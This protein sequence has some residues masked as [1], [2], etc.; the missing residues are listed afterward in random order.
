MTR[1]VS[2]RSLTAEARLR[3]QL[4]RVRFAVDKV[5]LGQIF[6]RILRLFIIK[7]I[8]PV[9]H[10]HLLLCVALIS[11]T[12]GRRLRAFQKEMLFRK[13]RRSA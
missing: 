7:I 9:F 1:A 13:S 4:V 2:R 10:A 11:R 8:Q 5:A 6:F 12:N 3:S